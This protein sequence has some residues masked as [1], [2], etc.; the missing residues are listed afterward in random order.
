MFKEFSL[1]NQ[2]IYVYLFTALYNL[3]VCLVVITHT[4]RV[5]LYFSLNNSS[6]LVFAMEGRI[7][8]RIVFREDGAT[9]RRHYCWQVEVVLQSSREERERERNFLR[10]K[11][12]R[13]ERIPESGRGYLY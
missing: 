5:N 13:K 10:A 11:A 7:R 8:N 2:N 12:Q 4:L 9:R 3:V 1:R 6:G